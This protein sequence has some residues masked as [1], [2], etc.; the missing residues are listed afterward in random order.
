MLKGPVKIRIWNFRSFNDDFLASKK[1][2]KHSKSLVRCDRC[3]KMIWLEIDD[4]CLEISSQTP[5]GLIKILFSFMVYNFGMKIHLNGTGFIS[6]AFWTRAQVYL[7]MIASYSLSIAAAH[8]G[9]THEGLK[10]DQIRG[11]S[12]IPFHSFADALK[13]EDRIFQNVLWSRNERD[14]L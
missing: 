4:G 2:R 11:P 3:I 9:S 6:G 8:L 13:K 1:K 5:A 12:D 7:W 10:G 14:V